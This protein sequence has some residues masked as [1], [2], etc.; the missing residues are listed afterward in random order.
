MSARR[1][2]FARPEKVAAAA[3]PAG[4]LAGRRGGAVHDRGD[5]VEGHSEHVVEH[6]R[7]PFGR[8]QP[9]QHHEQGQA[10]RVGQHRL[11]LG[12]RAVRDRVAD[13]RVDRVLAAQPAR[14]Q[15][16]QRHPGHDRSQPAAQVLHLVGP[17][18]AEPQPG[19]LHGVVRLARRAEHPV[20]HGP[21]MGPV[22]L[23]PLGEPVVFVHEFL[24]NGQSYH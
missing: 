1:A 10:D 20:S 15:H 17:G 18:P 3:S 6:E 2:P 19:F 23:E 16:V 4:Q 22:L 7:E 24:R 9:V 5:L 13:A 11:M 14:L 12:V 21:Q 8:G